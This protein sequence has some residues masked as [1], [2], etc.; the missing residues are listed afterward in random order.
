MQGDTAEENEGESCWHTGAAVPADGYV[1]LW[2]TR[3]LY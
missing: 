1:V 3:P 2:E